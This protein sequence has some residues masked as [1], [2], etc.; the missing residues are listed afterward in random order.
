MPKKYYYDGKLYS[1]KDWDVENRRPATKTKSSKA[2]TDQ[3]LS[4]PAD[5]VVE[6][7]VESVVEESE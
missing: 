4:L 6:E 3:D 1:P 7:V 2:T 5:V